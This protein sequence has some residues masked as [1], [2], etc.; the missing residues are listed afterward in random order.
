MSIFNENMN[1]SSVLTNE[2]N[3]VKRMENEKTLK[4]IKRLLIIKNIT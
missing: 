1:N 2:L 4:M 3:C